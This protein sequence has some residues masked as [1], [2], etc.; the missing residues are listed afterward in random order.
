VTRPEPF[1]HRR[2]VAFSET[3]AAGI[4]H[5]SVLF[6][7]MEDAEHALLRAVDHSVHRNDD[8]GGFVGFPRVRADAEFLA[9]IRFEEAV[10]VRT[11]VVRLG[12]ASI[13]Y[14]F[15]IVVGERVCATGST[16]VVRS[17]RA[18][19][20]MSSEPL[21]ASLRDSLARWVDVHGS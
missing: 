2:V 19:G 18:S 20:S 8:A 15:E 9:P 6:R 10:D 4:V 21:P 7:Y 5:F 12:R 11:W 1:V 3:D 13:R 14:R 16:T 17:R